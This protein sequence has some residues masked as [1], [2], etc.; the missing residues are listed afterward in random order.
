MEKKN[1]GMR[2]HT[3]SIRA[4]L[5]YFLN[6]TS[7]DSERQERAKKVSKKDLKKFSQYIMPVEEEKK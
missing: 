7:D 1:R 4:S 6:K 2:A 5:E 3:N